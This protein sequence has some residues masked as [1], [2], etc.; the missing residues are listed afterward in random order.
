[1]GKPYEL[2][3]WYDFSTNLFFVR[4]PFTVSIHL[5]K[6]SELAS[7][8]NWKPPFSYKSV[9]QHHQSPDITTFTPCSGLQCAMREQQLT[10]ANSWQHVNH[11]SYHRGNRYHPIQSQAVLVLQR[12]KI[13]FVW[14]SKV[15]ML[16][17]INI[18][19]S[20]GK[21]SW[22]TDFYHPT[23]MRSEVI[24]ASAKT[25]G[26]LKTLRIEKSS[27]TLCD[28]TAKTGRTSHINYR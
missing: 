13:H 2:C 11:H 18:C 1:M 23:Q 27:C 28:T 6:H 22:N 8:S 10:T 9:G 17:I 25:F 26:A 24:C 20:T 7:I 3:T 12:K 4:K 15:H 16:F 19:A 5:L 21:S 14:R